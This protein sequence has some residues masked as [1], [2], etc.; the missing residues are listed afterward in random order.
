[1]ASAATGWQYENFIQKNNKQRILWSSTITMSNGKWGKMCMNFDCSTAW[2]LRESSNILELV[3]RRFRVLLLLLLSLFMEYNSNY[4]DS[5]SFTLSN[6]IN[7][8]AYSISHLS[9]SRRI[10]WSSS[11][12]FG[13]RIEFDSIETP[14]K[15]F[16]KEMEKKK[17]FWMSGKKL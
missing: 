8:M 5:K 13:I 9:I 3:V 2:G 11:F 17:K 6:F 10:F 14:M 15:E 12:R 1:M 4:R 16:K 7:G